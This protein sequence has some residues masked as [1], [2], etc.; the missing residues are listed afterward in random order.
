MPAA[1]RVRASAAACGT[2]ELGIGRGVGAVSWHGVVEGHDV[3]NDCSREFWALLVLAWA[4]NRW[5]ASL[6]AST[7]V[8]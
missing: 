1:I 6:R 5:G 7:K 2:I 4:G 8:A 3:K